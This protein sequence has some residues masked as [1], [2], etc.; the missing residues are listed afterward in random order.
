MLSL[1]STNIEY[2]REKRPFLA[3]Y[4]SL[5]SPLDSSLEDSLSQNQLTAVF[6]LERPNYLRL[7]RFEKK[8]AP[9]VRSPGVSLSALLSQFQQEESLSDA[10]WEC[11]QCH[12]R[13]GIEKQIVLSQVNKYVLFHLKR[14]RSRPFSVKED[15]PVEFPLKDL[16][17]NGASY[18]L[19]AVVHH[20]GT[21]NFGHYTCSFRQNRE[22][23]L[24]DDH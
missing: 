3:T 5:V 18:S 10:R 21:L 14:F 16:P 12:R 24:A 11:D 20:K 15:L 19:L 23:F 17:L 9:G 22:W 2:Y 1:L 13:V 4:L 6:C 7:N 8:S